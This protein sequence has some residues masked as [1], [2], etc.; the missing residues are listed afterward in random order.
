MPGSTGILFGCFVP[1]DFS[2]AGHELLNGVAVPGSSLPQLL[3]Q[4]ELPRCVL[5][6]PVEVYPVVL[7]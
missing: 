6:G 2:K 4:L 7:C 5:D 1:G 3:Q